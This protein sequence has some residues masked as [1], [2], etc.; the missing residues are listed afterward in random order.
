[1]GYLEPSIHAMITAADG[2]MTNKALQEVLYMV[3][4]TGNF[5]NSVRISIYNVYIN[6]YSQINYSEQQATSTTLV[7]T[8]AS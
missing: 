2:L 8:Y 7:Q 6:T 1:M 4:V 5:L 3:L